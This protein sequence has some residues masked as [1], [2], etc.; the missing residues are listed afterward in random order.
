MQVN[1]GGENLHES[2][3]GSITILQAENDDDLSWGSKIISRK[4]ELYKNYLN[5][6]S[7]RSDVEV[8]DTLAECASEPLTC[9]EPRI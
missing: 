8:R 6:Q 1:Q 9:G 2:S 3:Y 7:T 5:E 4:S